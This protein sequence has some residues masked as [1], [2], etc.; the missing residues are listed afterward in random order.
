MQSIY[1][2]RIIY[3]GSAYRLNASVCEVRVEKQEKS[4]A[5]MEIH[6]D[7]D[8]EKSAYID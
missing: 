8:F 1:I 4:R 3:M 7:T 5:G 6:R 2:G